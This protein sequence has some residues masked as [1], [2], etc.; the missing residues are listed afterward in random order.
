MMRSSP[1]VAT[2]VLLAACGSDRPP[3]I[4]VDYSATIADP[5]GFLPVDS[6]LE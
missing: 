1:L 6:E 3:P 2:M 4:K 5:V